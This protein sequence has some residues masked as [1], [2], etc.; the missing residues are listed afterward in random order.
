MC[1]IPIH[2]DQVVAYGA[3]AVIAAIEQ[4]LEG[5]SVPAHSSIE[6]LITEKPIT[7]AEQMDL[8]GAVCAALRRIRGPL[9]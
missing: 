4:V 3:A 7:D 5:Q 1:K 2:P 9:S 8:A 6:I